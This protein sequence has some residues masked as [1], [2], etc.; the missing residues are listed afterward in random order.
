M[1]PTTASF[2]WTVAVGLFGLQKKTTP[3]PSAVSAIAPRSSL[4]SWST[5][6]A[7][8]SVPIR[9]AVLT[10][11]PQEGV[12]RAGA[13]AQWILVTPNND[14]AGFRPVGA[15]VLSLSVLPGR[16]AFATAGSDR[17]AQKCT[18]CQHGFLLNAE[19]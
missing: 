19:C 4:S 7:R 10:G 14:V 3:A 15:G 18:S 17:R 5:G 13:E 1:K 2:P 9:C 6:I 11:D 12:E 16:L 8:T